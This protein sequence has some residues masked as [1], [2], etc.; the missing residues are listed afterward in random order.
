MIIDTKEFVNVLRKATMNF[1]IGTVQLLFENGK[2][3]SKMISE[4]SDTVVLLNVDNNVFQANDYIDFNFLNPDIN[5]I[6]FINLIDTDEAD[7]NI[8]EEKITL[9]NGNQKSNIHFCSPQIVNVFGSDDVKKD[10]E[11]FLT[12]D[13]DDTFIDAYTK[14][15]KIGNQFNNVYFN[16]EDGKFMMETS[17]RTNRYSNSLK[18]ELVNDVEEADLS[19]RYNFR[20]FINLMTVINGDA[21]NF[22]INFTYI[23]EQDRGMLYAEKNDSSEKYILMSSAEG[24]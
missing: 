19:M 5:L 10:T 23:R 2:V 1:S 6:P 17:D 8:T 20:T 14:I 4:T 3:Q 18:I 13:I 24:A 12:L 15:K 11:Y 16:V 7:I 9:I 22:S 21:D